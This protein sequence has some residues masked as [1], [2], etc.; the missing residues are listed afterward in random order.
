M[1]NKRADI[2]IKDRL[3]RRTAI[4]GPD[5]CWEWTG[6]KAGSKSHKYGYFCFNYKNVLAHRVSY[7]VFVGAIPDGMCVLHKCDNPA[8]VNPQHLTVGTYKE[9]TLDMIQKGRA[10]F[11]SNSGEN[12]NVSPFWKSQVEEIR[13]RYASGEKQHALAREFNVNQSSISKIV[14]KKSWK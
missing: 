14:R 9:N 4:K 8:C 1:R 7:T 2:P 5:E 13:K 6:P 11:T 12:H 10:N 3:L